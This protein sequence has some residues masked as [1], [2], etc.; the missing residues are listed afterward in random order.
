MK[1]RLFHCHIKIACNSKSSAISRFC[2]IK[3]KPLP[4]LHV[5]SELYC[6]MNFQWNFQ[7]IFHSK[8]KELYKPNIFKHHTDATCSS[9]RQQEIFTVTICTNDTTNQEFL[10]FTTKVTKKE[11]FFLSH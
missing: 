10:K 4:Y 6:L 8:F 7:E 2:L 9:L 3:T 1:I 11:S 5:N